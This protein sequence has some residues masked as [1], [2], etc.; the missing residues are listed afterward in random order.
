MCDK[1]ATITISVTGHH[2]SSTGLPKVDLPGLSS[3]LV[4]QFRALLSR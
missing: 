4:A 3:G 1:K 2:Q